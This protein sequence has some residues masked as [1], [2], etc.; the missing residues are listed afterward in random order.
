MFYYT[1]F[2][3]SLEIKSEGVDLF[4]YDVNSFVSERIAVIEA[5]VHNFNYISEHDFF[6]DHED[7]YLNNYF[8]KDTPQGQLSEFG[9]DWDHPQ[10]LKTI[11]KLY[12]FDINTLYSLLRKQKYVIVPKCKKTSWLYSYAY[13]NVKRYSGTM[14]NTKIL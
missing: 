14:L 13:A 9:L 11:D 4:T 2:S 10:R 5:I 12:Y 7:Q 3:R 1:V 6:Y 8:F